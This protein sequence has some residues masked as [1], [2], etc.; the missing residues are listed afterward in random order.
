[1]EEISLNGKP[2]KLKNLIDGTYKEI[3]EADLD[4]RYNKEPVDLTD[5][6]KCF[7]PDAKKDTAFCVPFFEEGEE[8]GMS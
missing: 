5:I 8:D 3:S 2:A 6:L 4:A 7:I 1:M